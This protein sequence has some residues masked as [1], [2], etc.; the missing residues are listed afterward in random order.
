LALHRI[1][2]AYDFYMRHKDQVIES[3]TIQSKIAFFESALEILKDINQEAYIEAN[4]RLESYKNQPVIRFD[5]FEIYHFIISQTQDQKIYTNERDIIRDYFIDLDQMH[6]FKKMMVFKVN[7]AKIKMMHYSKKLLLEK[8]LEDN[9]SITHDILNQTNKHIYQRS[10]I[11]DFEFV[12]DEIEC[13]FVEKIN[14]DT[15]FLGYTS[16][17]DYDLS[18]RLSLVSAGLLRQRLNHYSLVKTHQSLERGYLSLLESKGM[19]LIKIHHQHLILLNQQARDICQTEKDLISMKDFQE[20]ISPMLYLDELTERVDQNIQINGQEYLMTTQLIDFDLY[21]LLDKTPEVQIDTWQPSSTQSII[22]IDVVNHYQLKNDWGYENYQTTFKTLV[23]ALP[24]ATNLHVMDMKIESNHQ[25]C[26]LLNNRDKRIFERL[27]H[28]LKDERWQKFDIRYA[29]HH[30]NQSYEDTL[31]Q[32]LKL[33]SM[34]T[35]D[36]HQLSGDQPL[37]KADEMEKLYLSTLKKWINDQSIQL[38]HSLIKNWESN[39]VTHIDID[40][41]DIGIINDHSYVR[42]V[43][44][45]NDL[46]ILFDRLMVNQ[47]IKDAQVYNHQTKFILPVSNASIESKKAFNY[48]LRR[49]KSIEKHQIIFKL[50]T[51]DYLLLSKSDQLYL[52]DKEI[53]IA[54]IGPILE[55]NQIQQLDRL[56]IL[57][58]DSQVFNSDLSDEWMGMLK[59]RF[60]TIIYNHQ[61]NQLLK[62][63]LQRLGIYLVKG[64]FSGEKDIHI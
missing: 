35:K 61:D 55:L 64:A 57:M 62:K 9:H 19:G 53:S 23:E 49:L 31:N 29:Y 13:I 32:L 16:R 17:D 54:L 40:F 22:L 5:D 63:D 33:L 46:E 58:I 36:N 52:L 39:Q 42:K 3:N 2:D 15:Y 21:V 43:L 14:D 41:K 7:D 6:A 38:R 45:S 28:K 25:I 50:Q 37:R 27:D 60:D 8:D 56:S 30:F 4:Q 59:K 48:L 51:S 26:I 20:M 18:R 44:K 11:Q 1:D 12:G 47:L 24:K 34:T 10:D